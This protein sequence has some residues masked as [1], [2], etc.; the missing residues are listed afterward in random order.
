MEQTSLDYALR[1]Y[2]AMLN[3]MINIFADQF[4]E[5]VSKAT[6]ENVIGWGVELKL[7][8]LKALMK[9]VEVRLNQ[10]CLENINSFFNSV[11][12]ANLQKYDDISNKD[13]V[14]IIIYCYCLIDTFNYLVRK[15]SQKLFQLNEEKYKHL[16]KFIKDRGLEKNVKVILTDFSKEIKEKQD[17]NIDISISIIKAAKET[18]FKNY[19]ELTQNKIKCNIIDEINN[20]KEKK[21]NKD[22]TNVKTSDDLS[23]GETTENTIAENENL[24]NLLNSIEIDPKLN[25]LLTKILESNKKLED[26]NKKLEENNKEFEKEIKHLKDKDSELENKYEILKEDMNELWNY[27]N[28]ICNGRD[29]TKSIVFYLYDHLGLSGEYNNQNKLSQ[30]IDLLNDRKNENNKMTIECDKLKKFLHLNYFLSKFY[31]KIVHRDVKDAITESSNI[32]ILGKYQ[33]K[34][35]FQNLKLFLSKTIKDKGIQAI[36]N[37]TISDYKKESV[38]KNLEY[39]IEN[40]FTEENGILESVLNE[41][42]IESIFNY[43]DHITIKDKK[44]SSLCEDKFWTNNEFFEKKEFFLNGES[45]LKNNEC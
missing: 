36:I 31:N 20:E 27:F 19:L 40:L 34:E 4:M 11:T 42:D 10:E 43:F 41:Q 22:N 7:E 25:L 37:Q 5:N 29:I 2:N 21:T 32:K 15:K 30:I 23:E 3:D 8:L 17:K 44:F 9:D 33:F 26:S 28:L 45:L 24:T 38:P 6:F 16:E 12:N 14:S 35:Y 1:L 13:D 39:K 18:N